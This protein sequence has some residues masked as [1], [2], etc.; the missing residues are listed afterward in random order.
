[1][2]DHQKKGLHI[3]FPPDK[4][5]RDARNTFC[6]ELAQSSVTTQQNIVLQATPENCE[7]GIIAKNDIRSNTAAP[8]EPY[9]PSISAP[10]ASMMPFPSIRNVMLPPTTLEVLP[11][12]QALTPPD[13]LEAIEYSN[14][15][16][17]AGKEY[18]KNQREFARNALMSIKQHEMEGREIIPLHVILQTQPDASQIHLPPLVADVANYLGKRY[19]LEPVGLAMQI[20]AAFSIATWGRVK[21]CLDN[22]WK[23]AAVDM[24]IQ[25]AESGKMK[26]AP[27]RLFRKP[28]E[29]FAANFNAQHYI[30][31]K[32]RAHT[33]KIAA[34][35]TNKIANAIIANAIR[36]MGDQEN[37]KSDF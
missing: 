8:H 25:I 34:Q 26:S 12:M 7:S 33:K 19:G 20:L 4:K 23:E 27:I 10:G 14:R 2:T 11:P 16:V 36:K 1:M 24:L 37:E 35:A 30:S 21:V 15:Q 29:D 18:I 32:E 31:N 3:T 17:R 22:E 5:F 13:P 6:Q 9:T 28:F